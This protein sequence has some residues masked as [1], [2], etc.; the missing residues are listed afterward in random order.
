MNS[1]CFSVIILCYRHFEYLFSA[2]NS[3]L[4]QDYENI[5]L[6]ISDDGSPEFPREKVEEYIEQNKKSNITRVLIR[7][8]EANNGTVKHLN[9]ATAACTGEYIVALAGD[10]VF[11][12]TS[13]LRSYVNGFAHAPKDCYIEMA[14]TGM[15]D[16]DMKHLE[17]Y[18]LKQPVQVALEETEK[19]TGS[20]SLLYL[21]IRYGA[22]LPSTSTCFRS[23][24]FKKFGL[25]DDSYILIED[26]PMHLR[27][28]EEG[29]KIHYQNFVA[30][31]HRHGGISH[32][33]NQAESKSSILYFKDT[34]RLVETLILPR[35]D[36]LCPSD[37]QLV[38]NAQRK[39]L[40]W[41]D[42][43]LA[44]ANHNNG[45]LLSLG[46]HH[47][48]EA[49]WFLLQKTF[50]FAERMHVKLLLCCLALWFFIPSISEM[51]E[52]LLTVPA[53]QAMYFFYLLA[54]IAFIIWAVSFFLWALAKII[55]AVNRF[56]NEILAIG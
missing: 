37:R 56:P 13:V 45:K 40:L 29:W 31:K 38:K 12:N 22:C 44:R 43:F 42:A 15:Y 4:Q 36:V 35:L 11:Y 14:Q 32:G 41:I 48:L 47:P 27:L 19:G 39:Q 26:Y 51:S 54:S 28:A 24:F 10:D 55:L 30:I 34:K 21:L 8:E 25:F 3:A 1:A 46:I 17:S 20:N 2:I 16:R 53:E 49:V 7:Q 52:T 5:E 18:Y 23:A 6:I 50:L 9:H 33:Q